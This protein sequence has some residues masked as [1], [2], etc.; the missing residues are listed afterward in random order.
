V[1]VKG[2]SCIFGHPHL[3]FLCK[4]LLDPQIKLW[5]ASLATEPV[6]DDTKYSFV[7]TAFDVQ[8]DDTQ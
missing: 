4:N 5:F 7:V 2:L 6:D 8:L 3:F 1:Q